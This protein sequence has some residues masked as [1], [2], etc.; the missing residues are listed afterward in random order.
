[1]KLLT[2]SPN[3]EADF[4]SVWITI[5]LTAAQL[6]KLDRL[7]SQFD[8]GDKPLPHEQSVVGSK[9]QDVQEIGRPLRIRREGP[10]EVPDDKQPAESS[11]HLKVVSPNVPPTS[12]DRSVTHVM[13]LGGVSCP[14]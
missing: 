9:L 2:H 13:R 10:I 6:R 4:L 5:R 12:R 3:Q 7:V 1:M 14:G 8:Q 11:T